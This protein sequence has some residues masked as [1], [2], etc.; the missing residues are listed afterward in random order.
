MKSK[1]LLLVLIIF[2]NLSNAQNTTKSKTTNLEVSVLGKVTISG[3]ILKAKDKILIKG[4]LPSILTIDF[5]K[6]NKIQF[7]GSNSSVTI[8][9]MNGKTYKINRNKFW[10]K[11][12][13]E[14]KSNIMGI[15]MAGRGAN[16]KDLAELSYNCDSLKL[17][18][19]QGYN[20]L[21]LAEAN[22]KTFYGLEC[23]KKYFSKEVYWLNT[24]D[25]LKLNFETVDKIIFKGEQ[26][27][28]FKK[29]N[30]QFI[31]N[32]K[33]LL[34]DNY[35]IQFLDKNNNVLEG[36]IKCN[37][38]FTSNEVNYY[39][40]QYGYDEKTILSILM[41]NNF[42]QGFFI[43]GNKLAEKVATNLVKYINYYYNEVD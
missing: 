27:I 26:K 33:Q 6:K 30:N 34:E 22:S 13:S 10:N 38:I 32:P 20:F 17:V 36:N 5:F 25:T 18:S 7:F 28:E 41:E 9:K 2:C 43:K 39:K 24:T 1:L 35:E 15:N 14:R 11:N 3:K 21:S 19:D 16:D 29:S 31:I 23:L 12:I 40:E 4:D 42:D 8:Q 37:F